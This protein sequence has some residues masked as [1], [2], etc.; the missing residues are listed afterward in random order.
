[1]DPLL[2]TTL[3]S[4]NRFAPAQR[5]SCAWATPPFFRFL[6][7][8]AIL[9]PH[10]HGHMIHKLASSRPA[11]AAGM[12]DNSRVTGGDGGRAA[13]TPPVGV[14]AAGAIGSHSCETPFRAASPGVLR[15][16]TSSRRSRY[17]RPPARPGVTPGSPQCG[18][19]PRQAEPSVPV[20]GI[21]PVTPP[22]QTPPWPPHGPHS[23]P[24]APP[25]VNSDSTP[26]LVDEPLTLKPRSFCFGTWNMSGKTHAASGSSTFARAAD[27]ISLEHL[28]I[29]A[30]QET[31]CGPAG[32]PPS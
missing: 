18:L 15:A 22:D 29:L 12:P 5:S 9:P 30:L 28:D 23:A 24:R 31:H 32:P 17:S 19:D 8:G 10:S 26:P 20:F 25:S 3:R 21:P 16:P 7:P 27:L 13:G 2:S 4:L 1:M 14:G 6:G 11:Q